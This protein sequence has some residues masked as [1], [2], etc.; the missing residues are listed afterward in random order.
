MLHKMLQSLKSYTKLS[1]SAIAGTAVTL[2]FAKKHIKKIEI[3][4]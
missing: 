2:Y 3:I 1:I 4:K